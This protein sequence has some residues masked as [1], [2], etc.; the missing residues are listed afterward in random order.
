MIHRRNFFTA[1]TRR[2]RREDGVSKAKTT[3]KIEWIAQ[4]VADAMLAVNGL[5]AR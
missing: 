3:E 1:K 5:L 4:L 2:T